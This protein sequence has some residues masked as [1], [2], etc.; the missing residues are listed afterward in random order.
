MV[1]AMHE[2]VV[3][4]SALIDAQ[5]DAL[6]LTGTH[7]NSTYGTESVELCRVGTFACRPYTA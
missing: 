7:T 3:L 6:A 4:N 2:V 5:A 1:D